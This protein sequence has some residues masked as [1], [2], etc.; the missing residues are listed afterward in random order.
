MRLSFAQAADALT[1]RMVEAAGINHESTVLDLGSGRG[2]ACLQIAQ[3]TGAACVG[4]DLTPGNVARSR[5]LASQHP[6]LN[7]MFVEG[8]F[9]SLPEVIA[10]ARF[11]HI[12]SAAAFVHG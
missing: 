11:T 8:S 6:E 3:F 12:F 5:E 7:L 2:L 1:Q 9:T 4:L 10:S